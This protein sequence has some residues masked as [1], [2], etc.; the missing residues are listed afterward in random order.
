MEQ[1]KL[2]RLFMEEISGVDDPANQLP[3]WMVTKATDAA[4]T[5]IVAKVKELLLGAPTD[6]KDDIDMERDELVAILAEER[7]A[8]ADAIAK[9][10]A[11]AVSKSVAPAEGATEG[12]T[13]PVAVTSED[14]VK[15]VTEAVEKVEKAYNEIL[16]NLI[17]RLEG[18]E[19]SLGIAARK[20]LEGQEDGAPAE[21]GVTKVAP[22]T[23][24]LGDAIAA[25]FKK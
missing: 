5:K 19:T 10:V 11:E 7:A 18:C 9:A 12:E 22:K 17:T 3:G 24:D 16:E 20:S 13:E 23:P 1:V 2:E 14:V 21:E 15:A 25:A 6:G 8:N 4:P